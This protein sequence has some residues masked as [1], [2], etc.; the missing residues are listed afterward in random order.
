MFLRYRGKNSKDTEVA[1][2]SII[3]SAEFINNT[4]KNIHKSLELSD[5][6]QQDA[7]ENLDDYLE[8][9]NRE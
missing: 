5:I 8:K 9:R 3:N 6:A 1:S 4:R 2:E 7:L